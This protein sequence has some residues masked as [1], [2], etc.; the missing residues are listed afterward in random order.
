M[1]GLMLITSVIVGFLYHI[2]SQL[3]ELIELMKE[4]KK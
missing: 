2:S 1:F 4:N 3:S